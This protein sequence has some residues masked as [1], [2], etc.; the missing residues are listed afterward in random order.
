MTARNHS[1]TAIAVVLFAALLGG[2]VYRYSPSEERQIRRHLN[3]LAELLSPSTTER[4]TVRLTRFA[5][6]G[7]YFAEGV[8]V[9]VDGQE[10]VSRGAVIERLARWQPP[11]GGGAVEVGDIEVRVSADAASAQVDLTARVATSGPPQAATLET[12]RVRVEMTKTTGDWVIS[13]L[14]A[15]ARQ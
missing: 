1:G 6:M 2:L 9:R 5:A 7:E 15:E 11:P 10:I 8:Q 12:R 3:N 14:E 4:E 13:S